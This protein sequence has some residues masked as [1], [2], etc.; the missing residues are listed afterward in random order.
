MSVL[1][2]PFEYPVLGIVMLIPLMALAD[3]AVE[4]FKAWRSR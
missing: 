4:K 2:L 3:T 1:A